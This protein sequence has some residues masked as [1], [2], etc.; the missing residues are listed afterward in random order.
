MHAHQATLRRLLAAAVL[1]GLAGSA[2]GRA[3]EPGPTL[4]LDAAVTSSD[5]VVPAEIGLGEA[6]EPRGVAADS[7]AGSILGGT[8]PPGEVFEM[9]V[10]AEGFTIEDMPALRMPYEASSGSWFG[11]GDYYGSAEVLFMSRGR[12]YRRILGYDSALLAL[13]PETFREILK[14]KQGLLTTDALP[15]NVSPGARITLGEY[16][17]RDYLD[18]DRSLELTYYGGMSFY[19]QDAWNAVINNDVQ[20]FL[21][22]PLSDATP[23]FTGAQQFLTTSNANFNSLELNYKIHRRLGRDQM[24]MVPNGDWTRHAER[25][26]L[27][28]LFLGTRLANYNEDFSF[29][30]RAFD[31]PLSKFGGDYLI[32][33][34]NWLW[35]FN[36]GAE[37]VSRNEFFY[38]GLRGRAAPA[39]A[40]DGTQQQLDARN[41]GYQAPG[42]FPPSPP[43]DPF[44]TGTEVW[45]MAGQQIGPGFLGDLTIMAGWNITP[46]SS[47]Q[48]GYDFLWIAG[49][50][51]ASRQFNLNKIKQNQIDPGG[52]V[53][54]QGFSFGY[55]GAW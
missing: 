29:S 48:L 2:V 54:L 50:A 52:Q 41:T 26:W 23:G 24:V 42:A 30:G 32:Q 3:A 38:W 19:Q 27:P 17:G 16:L 49:V 33:T 46:N 9:P 31:Q 25:G 51:T 36:L 35:G 10:S 55:N 1:A 28:S 6:L 11:S 40:F 44:P 43:R 45:K 53:F 20:T 12:Q 47:L 22:T 13:N 5:A 14:R 37:L 34:Q 8:E 21:V 7:G 18:R 4:A 15:Y 39:I